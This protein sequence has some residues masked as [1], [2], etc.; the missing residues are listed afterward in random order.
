MDSPA[1]SLVRSTVG[2]VVVVA[3][4]ELETSNCYIVLSALPWYYFMVV[5]AGDGLSIHPCHRLLHTHGGN[6]LY[7]Q[8]FLVSSLPVVDG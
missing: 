5:V 2:A 4:Q 6:L 1:A 8:S 7:S 3:Q